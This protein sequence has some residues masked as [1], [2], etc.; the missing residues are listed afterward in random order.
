M[1]TSRDIEDSPWAVEPSDEAIWTDVAV[2]AGIA[3]GSLFGKYRNR[4]FRKAYAA[5][6]NVS[7][8]DD[9]MASVF[10]ELWKNR[11]R[12]HFVDGSLWPWLQ[13]TTTYV[14]LNHRRACWRYRRNLLRLPSDVVEADHAH[15]AGEAMDMHSRLLELDATVR[16]LDPR[17]QEILSM[18]VLGECTMAEAAAALGIPE[19]TVKSRLN[20]AKARMR[21]RLQGGTPMPTGHSPNE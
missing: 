19:G 18:C 12:V 9:I 10:L 6:R 14:T 17:D 4:V 8:S 11:L 1:A 13:N 2:D 15:S 5:I 20:R 16:E 3:F 21:A 7:D